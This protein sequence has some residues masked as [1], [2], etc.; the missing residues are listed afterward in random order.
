MRLPRGG[1]GPE[2]PHYPPGVVAFDYWLGAPAPSV[3]LE[4]LDGQDVLASF[5]SSAAEAATDRPQQGMPGTPR[6]PGGGASNQSL[7]ATPGLHRFW[8]DLRGGATGRGGWI[9]PPGT[10]TVRLTAG[11]TAATQSLVLRMD[12][13]VEADGVTVAD[14]TEQFAFSRRV[15]ALQDEARQLLQRVQQARQGADGRRAEQ[16]DAILAQLTQRRDQSYPQPMLVEQI[17]YLSNMVGSADQKIG[18]DAEIRFTE[19]REWLDREARAFQSV[20]G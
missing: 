9:V 15:A 10:Y 4:I 18:R 20:S 12:P 13:R 6:P 3:K 17:G 14:L 2:G 16:L 8:W 11:G 1:A 7:A 19:L 5:E